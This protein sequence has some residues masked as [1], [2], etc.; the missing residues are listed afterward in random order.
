[1]KPFHLFPQGL[2]DDRIGIVPASKIFS[3]RMLLRPFGSEIGSHR[4][5]D[6][7]HFTPQPK[8]QVDLINGK[9]HFRTLNND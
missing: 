7:N 2:H 5:N 1:M 6:V 3:S 9:R 4:R 8:Q